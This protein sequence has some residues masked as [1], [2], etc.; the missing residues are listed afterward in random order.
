VSYRTV[1]LV[2]AV[3]AF[4]GAGVRP[5]IAKVHATEMTHHEDKMKC[6]HAVDSKKMKLKKK[7]DIAIWDASNAGDPDS[8]KPGCGV[9]RDVIMCSYVNGQYNP[10]L[11]HP[12][13][14]S[15]AGN[16]L[17]HTFTLNI[18]D[19]VRVWCT[20]KTDTTA[21]T[22]NRVVI[23]TAETGKLKPCPPTE[24]TADEMAMQKDRH[25]II[26]IEIVP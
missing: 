17:N 21:G 5:V 1:V 7:R 15:P 11:F 8:L 23:H 12:C 22:V 24:R 2:A 3:I 20:G 19:V 6:E 10:D 13:T 16:D 9:A 4:V 26:D 14:S 18:G 25:H